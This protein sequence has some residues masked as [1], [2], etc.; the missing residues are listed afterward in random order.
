MLIKER[1]IYFSTFTVQNWVSVFLDFPKSN[2]IILESL[3]YLSKNGEIIVYCFVIMRDHIHLVWEFEK[4]ENIHEI[5]RRFK[6]F[7]GSRV[8]KLVGSADEEYL[9]NF[10]SERQDRKYKFWKVGSN[11]YHLLHKDIIFQKIKYIHKNPLKGDYKTVDSPKDYFY[12]SSKFYVTDQ[13]D[14]K[15][16]KK[17]S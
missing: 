16:V 12:S 13:S 15:F 3:D 4:K 1:H 6:S 14:F 7:T 9:E 5:I 10:Q 17:F 8:I 2:E 11:D